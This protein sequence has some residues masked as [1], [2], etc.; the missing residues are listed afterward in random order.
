M[1]C[2]LDINQ[3]SKEPYRLVYL[4]QKLWILR[5]LANLS[6]LTEITDSNGFSK[7]S[8]IPFAV[9]SQK[10]VYFQEITC[11]I[12]IRFQRNYTVQC[13][14]VENYIFLSNDQILRKMSSFKR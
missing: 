13:I 9:S 8:L 12:L 11:L 4:Y 1:D 6:D 7:E 3:T 2:L 10:I 5:K 14:S